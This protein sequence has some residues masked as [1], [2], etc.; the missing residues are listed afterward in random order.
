M[1]LH[2]YNVYI[3]IYIL[4]NGVLWIHIVSSKQIERSNK[5]QCANI[6]EKYGC[7]TSS[8]SCNHNKNKNNVAKQHQLRL[9]RVSRP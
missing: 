8:D 5:S 7:I 1:I 6:H 3:Y 9:L 2:I 4:S